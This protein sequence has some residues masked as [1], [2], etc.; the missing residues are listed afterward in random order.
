L[1][2]SDFDYHLPPELIAQ[3]PAPERDAARMLVLH[4]DG[5]RIEHRI[6]RELPE[7]VEPGDVAVVNNTR[8]IPAR[9]YG[10]KEGSG[11]RVEIFF[12][13]ERPDG[14]WDVLLRS[15]RRPKPGARIPLGSGRAHAELIEELGGGAARVRIESDIPVLDLL[16]AEGRT[17]LPPY[18]RRPAGEPEPP[19]DRERYQTVF[20]RRPGA[21]AAPT[22]GLHFTPG[23]IAELR[24]GGVETVEVTLHVGP[25]TF[26]PV[27]AEDLSDHRMDSERYEITPDAA[28]SINMARRTG[29]RVLAVGTTSVRTLESA[30]RSDGTVASGGGRSE[31]FIHPPYEFGCVGAM[32]TNFHL[33][34]S[35]LLMLVSAF[36][37][38]EAV[39]D[40]YATA[41]GERYRFYSYGD[42]MLI[43]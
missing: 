43:V 4:R 29:H 12:L 31:L 33:P 21:V 3:S 25:G 40:A 9:V 17:P 32:L 28:W 36:A 13:E 14:T 23:L 41:V 30:V 39:L 2:T 5:G 37:G 11:G 35:T 20:A 18:I 7:Y 38:R 27:A 42:C 1:R 16:E 24:R 34:R 10:H 26:R 22:A 19:E 8:V 15:R 6:V